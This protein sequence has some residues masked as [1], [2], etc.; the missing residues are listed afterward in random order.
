M[1]K[2]KITNQEQYYVAGGW[3][4]RFLKR[5]FDIFVSFLFLTVFSWLIIL[6]LLI[7]FFEDFHRPWYTSIRIGKDCKP[8]HFHKIRSMHKDADK[9][10]RKMIKQGM[11]EADGPVFKMKEDPRITPFGKFLRKTS[12]DEILQ[13]WDVFRGKM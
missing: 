13:F 11:N 10:K 2:K 6:L 4:Y 12:L 7:K 5:S 8:F 9:L 3:F 1:A